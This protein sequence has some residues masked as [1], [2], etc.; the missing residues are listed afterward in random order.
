MSLE[1][2]RRKPEVIYGVVAEQHQPAHGGA[3][4]PAA[5]TC[6]WS[7]QNEDILFA[8][9]KAEERRPCDDVI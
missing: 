6:A 8:I 9:A 4:G 3:R 5:S 7:V 2:T 1:R